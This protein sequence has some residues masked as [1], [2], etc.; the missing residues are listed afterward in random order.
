[1]TSACERTLHSL[2]QQHALQRAHLLHRIQAALCQF[3]QH[4]VC[5]TA[6]LWEGEGGGEGV[7]TNCY[8]GMSARQTNLDFIDEAILD[9][10]YVFAHVQNALFVKFPPG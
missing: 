2:T 4:G 10:F 5:F 8:T 1:M 6:S 7:S 9:G 3:V